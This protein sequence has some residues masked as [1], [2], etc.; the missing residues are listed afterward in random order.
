PQLEFDRHFDH[1]V[2]GRAVTLGG[3]EPP[4]AHRLRRTIV[5]AGAEALQHLDVADRSIA[6]D[7]DLQDYFPGEPATPRLL[8]VVGFHFA[9]NAW[10][11]NPA[12]GPVRA[13]AD[14]AARARTD[15]H[16]VSFA[17]AG[18]CTRSDTAAAARSPAVVLRARLVQY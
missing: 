11:R 6:P 7:D 15:S 8:G 14:P 2:D 12:A 17:D 5:E 3:R 10:R 16:A 4:L 18:A 1:D 9:Q 13:A